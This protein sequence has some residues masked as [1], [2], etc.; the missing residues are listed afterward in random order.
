MLIEIENGDIYILPQM[1][2][3]DKNKELFVQAE[4]ITKIT[5][6]EYLKDDLSILNLLTNFFKKYNPNDKIKWGLFCSTIVRD[7]KK[8]QI[9]KKNISSYEEVKKFENYVMAKRSLEKI[10]N[11]WKN[12]GIDITKTQN[13]NFMKNYHVFKDFCEPLDECLSIHKLVENIKQIFIQL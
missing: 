9:D 10:N 11:Y 7:L 2:F 3:L 8:I 6:P 13:R 1:R 12:Q 5:T 4:K